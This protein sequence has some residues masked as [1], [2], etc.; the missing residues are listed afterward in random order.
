MAR[1]DSLPHR[2]ARRDA[3]LLEPLAQAVQHRALPD[4]GVV[5]AGT[6]RA[7]LAPRKGIHHIPVGI[8]AVAGDGV[9]NTGRS[10]NLDYVAH[11]ATLSLAASRIAI[12]S[13]T[14]GGSG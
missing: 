14:G 8:E 11:G 9:G 1:A 3:V 4:L 7:G 2:L 12:S 10:G 5:F 13:M 6:R